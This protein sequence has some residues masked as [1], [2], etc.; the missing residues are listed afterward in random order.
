VE[1]P[2]TDTE[3]VEKPAVKS[4]KQTV[5]I[6]K[7]DHAHHFDPANDNNYNHFGSN[8]RSKV[9]AMS[10]YSTTVVCSTH[11]PDSDNDAISP[12]PNAMNSNNSRL[13]LRGRMKQDIDGPANALADVS[14]AD[15][16][17]QSEVAMLFNSLPNSSNLHFVDGCSEQPLCPASA[18]KHQPKVKEVKRHVASFHKS[19][20]NHVYDS[21]ENEVNEDVRG[22]KLFVPEDIR[23]RQLYEA[24]VEFPNQLPLL[25]KNTSSISEDTELYSLRLDCQAARQHFMEQ[26][27]YIL[28]CIY[29]CV[30]EILNFMLYSY[31]L[32]VYTVY[33][34]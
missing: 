6:E 10:V 16:A 11:L 24:D 27:L 21:D 9:D 18:C 29:I 22:S 15:A 20:D 2:S 3:S 26:V 30:R 17:D 1:L 7:D 25:E 8:L 14:A 34:S 33:V 32:Y 19:A 13:T 28:L 4:N 5:T 12:S 23:N 31:I